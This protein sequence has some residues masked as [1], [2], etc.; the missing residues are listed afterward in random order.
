MPELEQDLRT[1]AVL[2][3]EFTADPKGVLAR[4]GHPVP[5]GVSVEVV[6]STPEK[7]VVVL[8]PMEGADGELSDGELA[9]V[10]GG[11][12]RGA[13]SPQSLS[14]VSLSPWSALDQLR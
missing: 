9:G 10:F 11:G 3:A 14:P 12:G 4:Y 13:V 7:V 8:P 5:D 6:E 2:R 1:D